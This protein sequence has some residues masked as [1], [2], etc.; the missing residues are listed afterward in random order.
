[1]CALTAGHKIKDSVLTVLRKSLLVIDELKE[2]NI[3]CLHYGK[4]YNPVHRIIE[5][6]L[7]NV[8]E[9]YKLFFYIFN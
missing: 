9:S 6:K 4:G 2:N 8:Y 7:K 3:N 1:M 5:Y